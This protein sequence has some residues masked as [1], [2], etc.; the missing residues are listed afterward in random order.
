[1]KS[2]LARA[3]EA[4]VALVKTVQIPAAILRPS[5]DLQLALRRHL[6]RR[7]VRDR[8]QGWGATLGILCMIYILAAWQDVSPS[9]YATRIITFTSTA[10]PAAVPNRS[11]PEVASEAPAPA[12]EM[13]L[14]ARAEITLSPSTNLAR[15]ALR[16][17]RRT[18]GSGATVSRRSIATP[19]AMDAP[20]VRFRVT[21]PG[22]RRR[23]PI[24]QLSTRI[25]SPG[26]RP[27]VER[28][29]PTLPIPRPSDS[30]PAI[31]QEIDAPDVRVFDETTLTVEDARTQQILDWIHQNPV[32]I[33][34]VARRHMDYLEGD[35]VSMATVTID[36][37]VVRLY[38]L[39]RG[40]YT[41]LHVL[42]VAGEKS[43]LFYDRGMQG[44][45]SRFRVGS[46]SR[47]DNEISRIVSQ[48]REITSEEAR[49]FYSAF[50]EWWEGQQ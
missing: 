34:L 48:E 15:A 44:E 50:L 45:A 14:P 32:E 37:Q 16:E 41:Q 38:L 7:N 4:V 35:H 30:A 25:Q 9:E 10:M 2:H 31:R 8:I 49:Q 6:A 26:A 23:T 43:Y 29:S 17:P 36:G 27:I 42:M 46:V 40:G 28:D 19:A 18:A 3:I 24:S 33:P 22:I 5:P 21:T 11:V 13:P 1:M 20:E 47:T 12:A 39:A